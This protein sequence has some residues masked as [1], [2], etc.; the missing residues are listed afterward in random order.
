MS[1]TVEP[2]GH[3]HVL[4]DYSAFVN[5]SAGSDRSLLF[6]INGRKLA[7]RGYASPHAALC[8]LR[9]LLCLT[10][11]KHRKGDQQCAAHQIAIMQENFSIRLSQTLCL[12][13]IIAAD[14]VVNVELLL[15]RYQV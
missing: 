13:R 5:E 6:V 2:G 3:C 8:G 10:L 12:N 9:R 15:A 14:R 4:K 7:S 1:P 11:R